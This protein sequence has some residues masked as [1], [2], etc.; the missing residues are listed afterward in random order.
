MRLVRAVREPSG[1][2]L[3]SD[4]DSGE[5]L[6]LHRHYSEPAWVQLLLLA[7][8]HLEDDLRELTFPFLPVQDRPR[9]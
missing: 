8:G 9:F 3:L 6:A 4:A 2:I 7:E 5:P 1:R